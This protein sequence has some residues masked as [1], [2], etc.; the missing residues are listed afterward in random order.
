MGQSASPWGRQLNSGYGN[1]VPDRE[2]PRVSTARQGRSGLG[3]DAQRQAVADYLNGGRRS[4]LREF[5]EVESG[6]L[7][8]RPELEKALRLCK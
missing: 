4:L 5:V 7:N 2:F 1:S 6:K 3:L 8:A